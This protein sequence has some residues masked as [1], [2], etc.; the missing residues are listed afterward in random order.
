MN[1]CLHF[2]SRHCIFVA[3]SIQGFYE[4]VRNVSHTT[5]RHCRV[6]TVVLVNLPGNSCIIGTT[7][8]FGCSEIEYL[9]TR[10]VSR[11]VL[12][13]ILKTSTALKTTLQM[14]FCIKTEMV[15]NNLP[16]YRFAFPDAFPLS[17]SFTLITFKS[18]L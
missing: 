13:A 1:V 15:I 14:A 8:V 18:D 7:Y 5:F 9:L 3:S 4:N 10:E 17:E 11:V 16:A 2:R 6:C 12:Q